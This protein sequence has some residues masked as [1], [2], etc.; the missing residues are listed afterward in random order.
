FVE[1]DLLR[2]G[3]PMPLGNTPPPSDYRI[4]ICRPRLGRTAD[5]YGFSYTTPIPAVTI[6]LLAGDVEPTLD[7][8]AVLHALI[9]RARYDLSIDYHQPPEPPLRP[10]DQSWAATI[11]ARARDEGRDPATG[12]GIRP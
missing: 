10:E 8:N 4:L 12:E 2:A 5:L 3:E 6:P 9:D 1:I 7:L 11:L